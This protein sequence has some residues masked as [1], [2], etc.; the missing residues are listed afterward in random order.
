VR[1]YGVDTPER[2]D[3]C[4]GEAKDRNE[5]LAANTVLL[6]LPDERNRDRGG[7][8]LRY[9]FDE[10]GESIDATLIAEGLARAWPDDGAYRDTL[11]ALEHQVV[12]ASVGC[13][14]TQ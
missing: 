13:L 1:Y 11:V 14:W 2:G 3:D 8:L 9:V 7:R 6:L 10:Q 12:A 5:A 4:Y